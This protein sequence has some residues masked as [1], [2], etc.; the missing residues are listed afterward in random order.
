MYSVKFRATDYIYDR[1]IY[2]VQA[3]NGVVVGG[4]KVFNF[5]HPVDAFNTADVL[6]KHLNYPRYFPAPEEDAVG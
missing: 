3:S 5:N 6:C 1:G 2:E 4:F